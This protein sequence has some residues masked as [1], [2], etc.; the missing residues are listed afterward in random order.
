LRGDIP[1]YDMNVWQ[2]CRLAKN[3]SRGYLTD[4]FEVFCLNRRSFALIFALAFSLAI[5]QAKAANKKA[6]L[7]PPLFS[8]ILPG[9][10]QWWENDNQTAA[11]YTGTALL[12]LGITSLAMDGKSDVTSDGL[13]SGS[14]RERWAIVGTQMAFTAGLLSARESFVNAY[15]T[16]KEDF[17]FIT[18]EESTWDILKAPFR[19]EFITRPTTFI[20]LVALVGLLAYE[21]HTDDLQFHS[22]TASDALFT[23]AFSYGA[24]TGEEAFFRGYVLPVAQHYTGERWVSNTLQALLF[25]FA[26]RITPLPWVQFVGGW[27]SGFVVQESGGAISEVV[28]EHFWWDV[29]AFGTYYLTKDRTSGTARL[30]LPPLVI[31]F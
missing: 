30:S 8:A 11:A 9:F 26:H 31:R 19:F 29:L 10:D 28:F 25:A 14:D 4:F 24:G 1:L 12:G 16:R 15:K 22:M 20:P 17:A 27:W 3:G 2:L 5:S 7:F 18:A 23:T 6:F 13:L 21:I